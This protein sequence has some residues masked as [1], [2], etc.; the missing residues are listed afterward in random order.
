MPPTT[1]VFA[2][3][4]QR[5][6][7]P[8]S[9][10]AWP[11]LAAAPTDR[12]RQTRPAAAQALPKPIVAAQNT[13]VVRGANKSEWRITFGDG[14]QVS[15]VD[16]SHYRYNHDIG[17]RHIELT[18]VLPDCIGLDFNSAGSFGPVSGL[19]GVNVL[20]HTRGEE[21]WYEPEVHLYYGLGGS[22]GRDV[23]L[24]KLPP[25]KEWK[26]GFSASGGI[27]LFLAWATVFDQQGRASPATNA[28][29][30][31]GFNWTG[32]FYSV[33]ISIPTPWGWNLAGSYFSSDLSQVR[34]L[35]NKK[36]FPV[37]T[38]AWT[39][40]SL[41]FTVGTSKLDKIDKTMFDI[42]KLILNKGSLSVSATEY[43]L[44]YGNGRD[45]NDFLPGRPSIS[46][47][48]GFT[49]GTGLFDW[50]IGVDQNNFPH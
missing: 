20:W 42:T 38:T 9:P 25:L 41:G 40:V 11:R 13:L 7:R 17:S 45:Y 43:V 4:R 47:W 8:G 34:H 33:G 23:A 21:T 22:A 35:I 5:L 30:A 36:V 27:S 37:A 39:G 18:G 1:P 24:D 12:Q 49:P 26:T 6:L 29:V 3:D 31:N 48:N 28:W 14:N 50:H 16:L 2:T 32:R 46:G 44:V 19:L 15:V 10:A